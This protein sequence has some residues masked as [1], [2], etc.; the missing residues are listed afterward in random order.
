MARIARVVAPGLPHHI[1]QRGNRRQQTFFEEQDYQVY[2]DLMAEW[3]ERF[4]V[5]IWAYCLMPNHVHLIA[6]PT[7][8]DGLRLA[9]GEAHRRFT[10][11]INF[12]MKWRGHLWQERFAS[13]PLDEEYLLA[14]IRYVEFNPV[15]ARLTAL[16]E[17]YPWSS[18]RA[19]LSG[20]DDRLVKTKPMLELIPDW[21]LFLANRLRNP[22]TV[23]LFPFRE[24]RGHEIRGQYIY[25][26]SAK[27]GDSISISFPARKS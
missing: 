15:R 2:L 24:I 3:C 20:Q 8:A 7:V 14:A 5:E 21:S 23:Y 25:F 9:I 18:A 12:R 16:P 10:R 11:H 4:D 26:L 22:G 13:F 17:E 27:S 6:V 19:H 1:T